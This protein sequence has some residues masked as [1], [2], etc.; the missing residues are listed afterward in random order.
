MLWGISFSSLSLSLFCSNTRVCVCVCGGGLVVKK[1][2]YFTCPSGLGLRPLETTAVG[3]SKGD[4]D[5]KGWCQG[6][7]LHHG[8]TLG[9]RAG[10]SPPPDSRRLMPGPQKSRCLLGFSASVQVIFP[11]LVPH[12]DGKGGRLPLLLGSPGTQGGRERSERDRGAPGSLPQS[13]VSQGAGSS[14]LIHNLCE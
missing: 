7:Q 11:V 13:Q 12:P 14:P 1:K 4:P 6:P 5:L 8:A 10:Q 3:A 9:S 2:N